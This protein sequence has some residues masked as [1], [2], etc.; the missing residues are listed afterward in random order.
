M[1]EALYLLNLL[2]LPGIAFAV[3]CGLYIT[4]R[5]TAG[6]VVRNHLRQ[7]LVASLWAGVLLVL[8][9]AVALLFGGLDNPGT[10]VFLVLYF[11]LCHSTLI[12]LGVLG[13]VRAMQGQTFRYSVIG[14]V[15]DSY[16]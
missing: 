4:R 11:A 6:P 1:A 9:S 3:L 5:R 10:W 2:L 14:P 13:L 12:L 15:V 8:V 16:P 7:A